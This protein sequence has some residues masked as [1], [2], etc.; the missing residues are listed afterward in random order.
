MATFIDLDSFWRDRETY[1]NE[2]DYEL[3]SN[4]IHTW[5]RAPRT[6]RSSPQYT[7]FSPLEFSTTVNIR[8]M[9]LPYT[10][11]LAELPRI[12]V[13]FRSKHYKD[14]HLITSIEGKQMDSKFICVPEKVQN[15]SNGDPLWIHY[16]CLMEQA[17]RFNRGDPIVLQLTT[18]SG[19]VLPQQDSPPDQDPDPLK[20]S[21]ITFE[22]TP[23]LRD[24]DY[25]H[26]MSSPI[27]K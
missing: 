9:T 19:E 17:M 26:H 16:K 5:F 23:Y 22:V 10:D 18:R 13:N 3:S 14:V 1:P 25:N 15:D 6:V 2:N 11:D 12:Y 20:Q 7:G 24:G 27:V 21:L 8:Y 4:K